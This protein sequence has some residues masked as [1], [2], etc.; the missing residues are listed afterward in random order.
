MNAAFRPPATPA[1]KT[2]NTPKDHFRHRRPKWWSAGASPSGRWSL[3]LFTII[4]LLVGSAVAAAS[5]GIDGVNPFSLIQGGGT[6]T[7][8]GLSIGLQPGYGG[9]PGKPASLVKPVYGPVGGV[10]PSFAGPSGAPTPSA[11]STT[12]S[13]PTQQP[14]KPAPTLAPPAPPPPPVTSGST[15]CGASFQPTGGQSYMSTLASEEGMIGGLKAVRVFYPG[16]PA[17]WPG[18]AGNV[19]RTVVV[20]FK[21]NPSQILNGS[22]D[23]TMRQWFANAPRDR[24]IYWVYWH[25][26]E[27]DI[28]NGEFTAAQYRSAWARLASLADEAHNSKLHATLVLMQWSVAKA[29]GRNWLDYYP[30]S[31]VI[32]VLGWD[33]Y[34]STF[35]KGTYDPPANLLNPIIAASNSVGKR[36]GVAELG[37]A[38]VPSDPGGNARAAWLS[39]VVN[40]LQ[41]NNVLW[42]TYFD[43]DWLNGAYDYRLRDT[44]SQNVWRSFCQS[45]G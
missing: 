6:T 12:T 18:N 43:L 30:G 5:A 40:I 27:D 13:A 21:Y 45:S 38:K 42:A 2:P 25:E 34:N 11:S 32:D 33:V 15:L 17:A 24:D 10:P 26:P 9:Q 23:S 37:S 4:V 44:A 35:K 28:A 39:Q 7:N 16:A 31:N 3:R 14:T 36:W 1:P 29:S 22:E 41:N 19:N 8:D 20:S